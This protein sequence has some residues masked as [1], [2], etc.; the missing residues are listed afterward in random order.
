M[1]EIKMPTIREVFYPRMSFD[2]IKSKNPYAT[3]TW[4]QDTSK[5]SEDPRLLAIIDL[6]DG[7]DTVNAKRIKDKDDEDRDGKKSKNY[8]SYPAFRAIAHGFAEHDGNKGLIATEE[9]RKKLNIFAPTTV[10]K[11]KSVTLDCEVPSIKEL[12]EV[13]SKY[14]DH[15]T[16]DYEKLF[17][18][19][20]IE[21]KNQGRVLCPD[22]R[23]TVENMLDDTQ[24]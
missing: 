24:D 17:D 7:E 16:V 18:K 8:G 4:L 19:V 2:E 14:F 10:I 9:G 6:F 1:K 5:L 13:H 23:T 12:D 21:A 3:K 22:W 20:E 15:E 11:K